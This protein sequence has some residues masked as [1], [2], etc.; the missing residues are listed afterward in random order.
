LDTVFRH[1]TD[2]DADRVVRFWHDSGASMTPLDSVEHVR[3]LIAHPAARLLL[4]EADGD[5]IGTLIGTFDGW[6]GN[7]Y[8]LVVHPARRRE[9]IARQLV[10]Q[11]EAFFAQHGARRITVLVEADR[12]WAAEFWTAI[13]Y[14]LDTHV[15]RH[16]GQLL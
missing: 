11:I 14:P 5:I 7:M 16:L 8:R 10:A 3:R 9:G 2:A 4:A 12:P 6:R 1:A 15:V 13:G